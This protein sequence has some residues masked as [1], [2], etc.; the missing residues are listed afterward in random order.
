MVVWKIVADLLGQYYS[1]Y[2]VF[3]VTS[4]LW[5]ASI[6]VS[7]PS[8]VLV[9]LRGTE[10]NPLGRPIT[11]DESDLIGSLL[12]VGASIGPLLFIGIVER[13]GRK[14]SLL[15]SSAI[16]PLVFLTVAF[17]DK[18]EIYLICRVLTGFYF[19]VTLSIQPS[20]VSEICTPDKRSVLMSFSTL[21]LM[22]GVSTS[23]TVGDALTFF[24]FNTF[25][26]IVSI[27]FMVIVSLTCPESP[28]YVMRVEG[29]DKTRELLKKIRQTKDVED[30]LLEIVE[31]IES[32]IKESY[33]E[34]FGSMQNF[35]PFVL[36]TILLL[37]Q[38][39]TGIFVLV[40]YVQQIFLATNVPIQAHQCSMVLVIFQMVTCFL[41]PILMNSRKFSRKGLLMFT[42]LGLGLCNLTIGYY[43]CFGR[44][45][46]Y[47]DWLP[48]VVLIV[49]IFIFNC[50]LD[51][52]PWML[53][54][55]IYPMNI[56][57]VGSALST[58]LYFLST[59]PLLY[60]FNKFAMHY[61]FLS[62]GFFSVC[63]FVFVKL[64][65]IDTEGKS[66]RE[67]HKGI[68]QHVDA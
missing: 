63:G 27:I 40:T 17:T 34:I 13:F 41:P 59:F 21:F 19:G 60:V 48:L 37:F 38:Q 5:L 67:I 54:G 16:M 32:E 3:V 11:P 35:K 4:S 66:L 46:D 52:I 31:T 51:P 1:T 25:I 44:N 18:I 57:S 43:F 61:L 20:Y 26:A 36:A 15:L 33:L 30:E 7:W 56:K 49:F 14:L 23:D 65:I 50:G 29:K 64:F 42:L 39:L 53:M 6:T 9:K 12:F 68:S 2:I 8:P 24:Q 47:L 28:Y 45:V 55:E 58:C 62:C 10:D 22:F